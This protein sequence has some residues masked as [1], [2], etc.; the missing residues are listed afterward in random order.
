MGPMRVHYVIH[1]SF[2]TPGS[3]D[4]WAIGRGHVCSGTRTY[5][6]QVLPDAHDIDFLIIMG[7]PQSPL[8]LREFPYL[9]DEINLVAKVIGQKKPVIGFCLGSQLIAEALGAKTRRSPEKEVGTFPVRLTHEGTNDAI[10]RDFPA[11]FDVLHWHYDMPGIPD[12]AVLL[13]RSMGCPHQ[14]FRFGDRVYGFQFHMEQT[15]E[16]IKSLL[17]NGADDL[18][19]GKYTQTAEA[20]LTSDFGTMN[21]RLVHVLDALAAFATHCDPIPQ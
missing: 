9:E 11:E 6:G 8:Q 16:S 20:I 13:A 18:T 7:G 21:S 2:E 3:I 15:A 1:A 10:L 12:G 4:Q 17:Q 5:E 19:A 14:A